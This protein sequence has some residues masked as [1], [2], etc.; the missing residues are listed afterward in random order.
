MLFLHNQKTLRSSCTAERLCSR[1][2]TADKIDG[3]VP[4]S[5]HGSEHRVRSLSPAT[6]Y[7]GRAAAAIQ[8]YNAANGL[9]ITGYSWL[10][11]TA[12]RR[13]TCPGL[14]LALKN[15]ARAQ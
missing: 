14:V 10:S 3:V 2:S 13:F 1:P 15:C 8:N 5:M 6:S 7:T 9:A 4:F 11:T 12:W